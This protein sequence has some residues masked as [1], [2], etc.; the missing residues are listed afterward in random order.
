VEDKNVW[1]LLVEESEGK[2]IFEIPRG[3]WEDNIEMRLE[4][5]RWEGVDMIN[6]AHCRDSW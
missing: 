5:I 6:L 3:R 2:R 1:R 4:G